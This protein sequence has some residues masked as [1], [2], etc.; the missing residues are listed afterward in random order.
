MFFFICRFCAEIKRDNY[1]HDRVSV[2]GGVIGQYIQPA[3]T[4]T[5]LPTVLLVNLLP[6][7]LSYKIAGVPGQIAAGSETPLTFVSSY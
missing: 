2:V 4:I 6:I 3:H 1:P 7:D 5:L